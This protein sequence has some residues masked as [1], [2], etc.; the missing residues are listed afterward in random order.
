[1][2]LFDRFFEF[3][4]CIFSAAISC[5]WCKIIRITYTVS[6]II[7]FITLLF[8]KIIYRKQEYAIDPK[9]FHIWYLVLQTCESA[10]LAHA[11]GGMFC[12][13]SYM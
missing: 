4:I 5:F 2:K 12:E 11:G 10:R 6:P 1:M 13:S 3:F 7:Y 8:F 9:I